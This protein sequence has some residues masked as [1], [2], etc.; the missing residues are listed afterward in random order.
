GVFGQVYL[1]ELSMNNPTSIA[2][3]DLNPIPGKRYWNCDREWREEFI[4]FLI[5]DRFHDDKFRTPVNTS[6]RAKGSGTQEQLKKFCG[7]TLRGIRENIDYIHNLGCSALWLSP[8]FENNDA[9]NPNSDKYHGYSIQSYLDIDPRFGTKQ[10]LIDLVE[11]AHQREMRVFLDIVINHSGDNW[12]YRNDLPYY[13]YQD[14]PFPFGGWRRE[15]RPI[16]REL[17]C[18]NYYHRRGQIRNWDAY[19]ETQR[20]D[21]FSLKDF[22]ND[23]DQHGLQ[24][25]DILVKA[26]CYWM[27]EAD[28]DGFRMD[29]VKHLGE[30]AVSRF[31]SAVREYSYRLGKRWFFLFGE[32]VAGDD[33]I[34]RYTGANTPTQVDNKTIYFGL[35]SVLD[36]PLYWILPNVIKGLSTPEN[37]INRYEALRGRALSRGELGR[38]L[39]TFVDNH[40]QIG[41]N[42][43]RRFGADTPDEQ[44]IAAIGYVL[45]AIGTPCIYY[46]TEQGF[47]G[48]GN[49][50]QFIREALFDLEDS[51]K[52]YLNQNCRIYQNISQI[53]KIFQDTPALRFGRMYFREI[54]GNGHDFG[55]PWGQ[56]CTLAFSRI[57][58]NQEILIAYNTSITER[59][60]DFLIVDSTI[61]KNHDTM[62]FLYGK[63]GGVT[64]QKHPDPSNTSLFVQ[65]NLAPM[66]F[67][68]LQ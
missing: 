63:E 29:A 28:I 23:D 16:P 27:R 46:G 41:Q 26:H 62:K 24:L 36:F 10:D 21:F 34:N 32:L 48:Q 52:S 20:G 65:I 59:R 13:Y 37:L 9:P 18:E 14:W 60:S 1:K 44:V 51:Q 2:E 57:L 25:L 30:L 58:D 7:G 40:D 68:I 49:G 38:Y 55:L 50:D 5:I 22:N 31:C 33:A 12:C 54:S 67:V 3:I 56:P 11:T 17:R 35:N 6:A 39:V 4:Y 64:V 53:A 47:S 61:H 66:Q 43:K 8:I 15:D 42:Y 19:P 45:C